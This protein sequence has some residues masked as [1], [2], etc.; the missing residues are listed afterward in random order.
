MQQTAKP[1]HGEGA[2]DVL[3]KYRQLE[4]YKRLKERF[5]SGAVK[6]GIPPDGLTVGDLVDILQIY[7]ECSGGE[8]FG[9]LPVIKEIVRLECLRT[10][11]KPTDEF[12]TE[13]QKLGNSS[14]SFDSLDRSNP[15]YLMA[16]DLPAIAKTTDVSLRSRVELTHYPGGLVIQP[17]K[18]TFDKP[19]FEINLTNNQFA[20]KGKTF[21]A[22]LFRELNLP[23]RSNII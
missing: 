5:I 19:K 17:E 3:E 20:D 13:Y 10:G 18:D 12:K 9:K 7:L 11:F 21:I 22:A 15:L 16:V 23:V 1:K 2:T 8:L 4:P 6:D 14:L